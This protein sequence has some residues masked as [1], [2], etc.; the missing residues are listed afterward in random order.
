M[1]IPVLDLHCDTSFALLGENL[2]TCGSMRQNELHIDLERASQLAGYAQFF[3]CF[4]TTPECEKYEI[5]PVELFER[6][7]VTVLRELERNSDLIAQAYTAEDIENNAAAGKMSA[8]LSVEGPAGIGFD[9]E[10]L[11]DLYQVG[12]RM[13]TLSWNEK[14][15]LTGSHK[16][17]GGLTDKG[18]EYVK[19]CQRLGMIVDVSHISDE[20]FWDIIDI[21]G[22]PIVASHSNSR[23]VCPHS[24]NI[25]DEMFRAICQTGGVVGLN[26][27]SAFVGQTEDLPAV[28]KHV[29]HF[30]QMDP[31]AEHIA[32][33]A[34]FDGCDK[35]P[36]GMN[37]IQDY[38]K[39]AHELTKYGLS[40]DMIKNIFWNNAMGV[41]RKCCM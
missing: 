26:Q 38:P 17:G 12:F 10:L 5:P 35:L 9:P 19:E 39:L 41:I 23:A 20:A 3:A 29:L 32:L 14:N 13:S 15:P 28:C 22:A 34:D 37:G 8:I 30:L 18:R 7:M 25:T 1:N 27:Y 2:R 11:Q 40:E 31:N 33:G 16:T 21:S 36:D 24:R 4:T 6:E